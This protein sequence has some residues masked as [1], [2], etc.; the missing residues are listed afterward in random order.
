MDSSAE[1]VK[2]CCLVTFLESNKPQFTYPEAQQ[3]KNLEKE[4][5]KSEVNSGALT[6]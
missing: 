6:W 2:P 4:I 1:E 3:H 5:M